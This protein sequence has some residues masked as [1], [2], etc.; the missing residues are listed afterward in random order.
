NA[1]EIN[2][3]ALVGAIRDG[4]EGFGVLVG[5]GLSSVPR[6]A[7][8]LGGFVRKEEALEVLCAILDAWREDPRY[9]LSRVKA[10]LK[11]MVDDIGPE[12]IR[13]LVEERIGRSLPDFRLPPAGEFR[14]HVGIHAQRQPGLFSVGAPVHLGLMSGAQMLAVAD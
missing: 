9:R 2:C 12:G 11:F 14:D 7:K 1:P 6:I 8:E 13:A 10:R 4:E 5:G 3:I